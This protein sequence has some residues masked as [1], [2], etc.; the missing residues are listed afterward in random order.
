[1]PALNA[2]LNSVDLAAYVPALADLFK[3]LLLLDEGIV[4]PML[5]PRPLRHRREDPLMKTLVKQIL[6]A[7]CVALERIGEPPAAAR[8]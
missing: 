5:Q 4:S 7:G 1:M 6:V 2:A 3:A 8:Q